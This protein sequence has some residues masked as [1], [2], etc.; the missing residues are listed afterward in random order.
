MRPISLTTFALLFLLNHAAGAQEIQ[1]YRQWIDG[2]EAGGMEVITT[3]D[4]STE[5]IEHLE[6]TQLERMGMS[7]RQDLAQTITKTPDGSLK[8][9]WKMRISA[10]PMVGEAAWSPAEPGLLQVKAKGGAHATLKVPPES[11]LWPGDSESRLKDAA[12]NLRPAHLTEFSCSTQQWTQLDLDPVGPEP[13]PGFPDTVHFHGRGQEGRMA[14]DLDSWISPSHGEVKQISKAGG[15]TILLQRA[16]LPGPSAPSSNVG[17]FDRTI[18]KL[19]PHPFLPWIQE[20]TLR[21]EGPGRQ[22]LPEDA[23]QTRLEENL[24]RVRVAAPP[25]ASEASEEP[26]RGTPLPEDAPFLAATPLLQFQ[27]PAFNGLL[28]RLKSPTN[29]TRWQLAKRVTTFVFEWIT[30]KDMSV[31]FASALEVVHIP[32]GD[33]TEH[34][35]LAVAILRKLGV[36]ARGAVGWAGLGEMMGLHFWV[37]VKLGQRWVPVDPTFDQATASAVRLKLGTTDLADLGSIGWDSA[38]TRFL[39]GV[40]TPQKPWAE[41]IQINGDTV[42]A[43][44]VAM[45]RVPGGRWALKDGRLQ[46]T[47]QDNHQDSHQILAITHP[48]AQ[49]RSGAK[50]LLGTLTN[51]QGWWNPGS[52]RLW[53]DLGEGRWLQVENMSEAA[54]FKFLDLLETR[55]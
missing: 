20:A 34:G 9:T 40:W 6:W 31:G 25:S 8:L 38:T 1:R 54:A 29:A 47:L 12:K 4:A 42:A 13:L 15:L 52:K 30:E 10:E 51:R 28:V 17:F 39:D 32:K 16:E 14:T 53:M 21:W 46:L 22:N 33:C 27:D 24:Y 50:L 37:E 49:Q 26:V 18:T 36:P 43:T 55:F 44:G 23:Q 48:S 41:A 5:R 7:L 35:V 3:K 2:I 11:I 45:L 19:P